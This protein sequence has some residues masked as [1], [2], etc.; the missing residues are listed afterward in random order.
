MNDDALNP[1]RSLDAMSA[2]GLTAKRE[3]VLELERRADDASLAE[4]VECLRD[5]SWFLRDLAEQA[6]VRLG[7]PGARAL[8]PLLQRG[9]WYTRT[10]AARVLGRMGHG[11]S[12]PDLFDLADDANATVAD[13][14]R[15]AVVAVGRQR[16]AAR[17]A[18]A[19]HRMPP[20]GRRRRLGEIR[21]R[22]AALF[23]RLER[24]M[25]S[26][27]LMA[28]SDAATLDDDGPAV[29]ATEDGVEWEVLTGPP[30]AKP[31]PADARRDGA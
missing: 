15:D 28:V 26:D 23:E 9:L 13:A 16:G 2:R 5:E 7:D 10:S 3:R 17:I 14:A 25:R 1:N 11:D 19:L 20:D 29:T 31:A 30:P 12:V 6:F 24:L 18:H 27:E 8:R 21:T 4:L 22:D